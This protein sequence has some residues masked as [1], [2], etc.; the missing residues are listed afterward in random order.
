M[1][2]K[3]PTRKITVARAKRKTIEIDLAYDYG[4]VV[5][6]NNPVTPNAVGKVV[7]FCVRKDNYVEYA[8]VWDDMEE[9]WHTEDE[10]TLKQPK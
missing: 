6:F 5:Y 4:D 1:P 9:R 2:P 3:K 10:L 7:G 8:V